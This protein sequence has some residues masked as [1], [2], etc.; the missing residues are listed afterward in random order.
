[1][2]FFII[3]LLCHA[4][5]LFLDSLRLVLIFFK[6]SICLF[7]KARMGNSYVYV[8]I[9]KIE[10]NPAFKVLPFCNICLILLSFLLDRNFETK[11]EL[12]SFVIV[13]EENSKPRK[14]DTCP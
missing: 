9:Q 2:K 10:L 5:C 1:M 6:E 13:A 12:N 4:A 8:F 14:L 11:C 7:R 3:F